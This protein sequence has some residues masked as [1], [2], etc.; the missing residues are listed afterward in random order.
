[1][2]WV[3]FS[4]DENLSTAVCVER[5]ADGGNSSVFH[6]YGRGGEESKLLG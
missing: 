6:E 2:N 4:G 1:M 5:A 3:D